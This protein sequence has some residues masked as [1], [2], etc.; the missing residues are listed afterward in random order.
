MCVNPAS[1]LS[2]NKS[3]LAYIALADFNYLSELNFLNND[4]LPSLHA[5]PLLFRSPVVTQQ[6]GVY[7][8]CG[9]N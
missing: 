9:S 2:N 6:V 3:M 4:M 5:S 1:F 7:N 8:C